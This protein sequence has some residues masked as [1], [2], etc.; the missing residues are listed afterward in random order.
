MMTVLKNLQSGTVHEMLHQ[1]ERLELQA[2]AN[3][4]GR[5]LHQLVHIHHIRLPKIEQLSLNRKPSNEWQNVLRSSAL[6]L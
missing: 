5:R 3:R 1:P 6:S 2:P 4:R